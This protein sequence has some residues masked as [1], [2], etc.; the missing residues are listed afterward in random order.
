VVKASRPEDSKTTRKSLLDA[1]NIVIAGRALNLTVRIENCDKNIVNWIMYYLRKHE[2]D[3]EKRASASLKEAFGG[4][5]KDYILG[6]IVFTYDCM[7]ITVY[8]QHKERRS[9]GAYGGERWVERADKFQFLMRKHTQGLLRGASIF[10]SVEIDVTWEPGN[11]VKGSDYLVDPRSQDPALSAEIRRLRDTE[12]RFRRNRTLFLILAPVV[13]LAIGISFV[14]VYRNSAVYNRGLHLFLTAIIWAYL[15]VPL[16]ILGILSWANYGSIGQEIYRKEA[17]LDLRS[18][19]NKDEQNAYKLFQLNSSELKR[20]Y[21]QALRQRGLV[22]ILG[23][24]CISGGFIVVG[25]T[26]YVLVNSLA[27]ATIGEKLIIGGLGAIAGILANFIAVIFLRMFESIVTSMVKFHNRLVFTNYIYFGNLLLARVSDPKLRAETLSKLALT[28]PN[29]YGLDS[30]NEE[31]GNG[32][33]ARAKDSSS[34][35]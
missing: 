11:D 7:Y 26:I 3:I 23:I 14:L 10:D 9:A 33:A 22:F 13:A 2:Y 16:T 18:V 34:K 31:I 27:H 17:S 6:P 19:L 20:Y 25:V 30:F 32:T 12:N 8:G 24:L 5:S 4:Q 21:D 15:V 28:L 35:K 29:L 1:G